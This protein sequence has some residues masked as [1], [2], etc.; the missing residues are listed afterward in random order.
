MKNRFAVVL[1]AFEMMNYNRG[2][3]RYDPSSVEFLSA[4]RTLSYHDALEDAKKKVRRMEEDDATDRMITDAYASYGSLQ[5]DEM[6]SSPRFEYMIYDRKDDVYY[7]QAIVPRRN[8]TQE[9][10]KTGDLE[11]VVW[12]V[13]RF[14]KEDWKR[15]RD[16]S[17]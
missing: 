12:R 13:Y 2:A 1:L 5:P 17:L 3:F 16:K 15:M 9:Q 10:I 6:P 11:K 4:K 14:T 7:S 8:P